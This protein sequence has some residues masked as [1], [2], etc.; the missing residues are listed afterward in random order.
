MPKDGTQTLICLPGE[1][2]LSYRLCMID[3]EEWRKIS[4]NRS[5]QISASEK[6]LSLFFFFLPS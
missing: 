1:E 4:D 5:E 2:L 6:W 3:Y